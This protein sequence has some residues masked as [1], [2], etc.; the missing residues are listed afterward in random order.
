[1][2]R[3][4]GASGKPAAELRLVDAQSEPD[5][6]TINTL[7]QLLSDAEQGLVRGALV[8]AHY[9]GRDYLYAGSGSLCQDPRLGVAAVAKL[10]RKLL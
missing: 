4:T 6:E 5:P 8:A 1:M 9:G 10:I 2:S 7:R 3:A